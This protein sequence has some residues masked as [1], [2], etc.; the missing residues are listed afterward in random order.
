MFFTALE[1]TTTEVEVLVVHGGPSL[2][3]GGLAFKLKLKLRG[4]SDS[5]QQLQKNLLL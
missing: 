4:N 5:K 3:H 1:S 2:M